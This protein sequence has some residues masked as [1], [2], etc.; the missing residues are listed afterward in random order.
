MKNRTVPFILAFVFIC[1]NV[2]R[3]KNPVQPAQAAD[4]TS[5]FMEAL[6]NIEAQKAEERKALIAQHKEKLNKAT[7]AWISQSEAQKKS[8]LN[9]I[10]DQNWDRLPKEYNF[11]MLYY[12][13][14]LRGFNYTVS[15]SE[16]RETDSLTAPIKAQV[17]IAEKIYAEK[18][19]A[20][21]VSNVD[22]YFFT[23]T[24]TITLNMEYRQD[25]FVITSADKKIIATENDCPSDLKRL[26][27]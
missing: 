7:K 16:I 1:L 2:S 14:Y 4:S 6:K 25:D 5:S 8:E 27:I 12:D 9:D 20:P 21:N 17:I 19:H 13:Y 15:T 11:T 23:V 26:K 24:T 18:Y 3:A 10:I 22:P